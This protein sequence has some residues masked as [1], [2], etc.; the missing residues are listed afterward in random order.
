MAQTRDTVISCGDDLPGVERITTVPAGARHIT[1]GLAHG[2]T[3]TAQVLAPEPDDHLH[4]RYRL[5]NGATLNLAVPGLHNGRNA[6]AALATADLL[7]IDLA[8]AVASLATFRGAARRFEL[9]GEAAGITVID[10]YAH[11]PTEVQATLAA[12]RARY[13]TRRLLAYVQPHTYSR[14]LTLFDDWPGAF[15]DADLVL[16]GDVYPSREQPP[17]TLQADAERDPRAALACKLVEHIRHQDNQVQYVGSIDQAVA[18]I[19]QSLVAGDILLT[20]G[21]GDGYR[22]GELILT[23]LADERVQPVARTGERL[24]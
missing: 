3:Y 5:W 9:K 1:Y 19:E 16:V 23:H 20:M 15:A 2:H 24:V 4:N 7:G 12:A 17:V 10:D 13:G 18:H 6:L 8:H 22:I 21:A 14:T 11:H